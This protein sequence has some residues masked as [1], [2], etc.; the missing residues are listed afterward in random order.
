MKI[1]FELI[2]DLLLAIEAHS[3]PYRNL[4]FFDT[5]EKA[6]EIRN[7]IDE[8]CPVLLDYQ[9]EL[10]KNYPN[11]NIIYHL[12]YCVEAN[13]IR[14]KLS[15]G[16]VIYV[17]DLTVQGHQY[18]ALVRKTSYWAKI[19]HYIADIGEPLTIQSILLAGDHLLKSALGL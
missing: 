14:I 3:T 16:V 11:E 1:N 6:A 2:R 8:P 15:N 12:R 19:K 5:S 10:E 4:P 7:A 17:D 9:I 13:L 18:V